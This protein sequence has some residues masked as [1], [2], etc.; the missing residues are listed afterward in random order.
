MNKVLSNIIYLFNWLS[1]K[2]KIQFYFIILFSVFVS[3]LEM[4]TVGAVVPFVSSIINSEFT[5]ASDLISFFKEQFQLVSKS[6]LLIFLVSLFVFFALIA[7]IARILLIYIISRFSNVILAEIGVS[8]YDKKLNETFLEFISQS[9]DKI[10]GLISAK[11]A[12]VHSLISGIMLLLT[13]SI[14]LISLILALLFIDF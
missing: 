7:G 4:I 5:F 3:A 6:D 10:I 8:I 9:S 11:L 13:S 2:R 14:L 12:Q 1:I